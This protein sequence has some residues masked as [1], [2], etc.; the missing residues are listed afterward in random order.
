MLIVISVC[1]IIGIVLII[2][3]AVVAAV[4]FCP[5]RYELV[6]DIDRQRVSFRVSWLLRLLRFRFQFE[7]QAQLMLSVLFFRIDFL[8]EE[9]KKKRQKKRESRAS[10]KAARKKKRSENEE[11]ASGEKSKK[12]PAYLR[13]AVR[14]LSNVRQYDVLESILPGLRV[15]LYRIRPRK[16][17][18][19]IEF[20]LEDPSGTGQIT[21]ALSLIPV[22]YQTELVIVPDFETEE[23]F[24]RGNVYARG[25]LLML[26]AVIFLV[27]VFRQKNVRQFIGAL[28]KKD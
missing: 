10:R 11:D 8:D 19:Q 24:I 4:L 14:I 7:E 16:L 20:G 22:F 25:H 2:L 23:S 28:R 5:V 1:K 17:R 6:L 18:G 27:R 13:M 26:H 9:Q 12:R 21:G 15:F 3:A